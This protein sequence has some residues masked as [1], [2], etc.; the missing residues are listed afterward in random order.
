MSKKKQIPIFILIII[1]CSLLFA[2]YI[3]LS[4]WTLVVFGDSVIGTVDS[5]Q[6]RLDEIRSEQNKSRTISK[7][8]YFFVDGKEYKCHVM[9]SSDESWPDLDEGE[10]RKESITYLPGF[11]YMNKP[12]MLVELDE[13]GEFAI[14][15]HIIAPIGYVLLSILIM[16]TI[17]KGNKKESKKRKNIE[18]NN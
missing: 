9:Y 6:A 8:Y 15:Y 14:I 16:K 17:K 18:T 4:T 10:T 11:P 13:M 2:M 3:S 1:F 7:G 12:S 5:Y